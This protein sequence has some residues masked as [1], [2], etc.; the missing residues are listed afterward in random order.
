[1]DSGFYAICTALVTKTQALDAV[2]NNLANVNTNGFRAEHSQF[3]SILADA[4]AG[5]QS[6]LNQAVNSYGVMGST[7]LDLQSGSLEKTGNDLDF[8]VN[9]A[10]FF[11]VQTPAG[12]MYTRAGNFTVSSKGQLVTQ[13]GD[14]VLGESG[15]INVSGGQVHVGP[16]GTLSVAGAVVGKLKVVNFAADTDL[17]PKGKSYYSAPTGSSTVSVDATIEQ[18]VLEDSN[19]NPI[20]SAVEL[21]NVQR[22]AEML[23]RTMTFFSN[24]LDKTAAEDLPR[25]SS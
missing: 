15:P 8:A 1:M 5:G 14:P 9:G 4:R 7:R 2:A 13:A 22:Q 19:A 17:S 10:G 24:D 21:I 16:D 6:A 18:G 25:V 20:G 3:K 11:A 23:E 12:E